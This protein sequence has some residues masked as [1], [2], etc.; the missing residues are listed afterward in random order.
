MRDADSALVP[1]V[2][3][4]NYQNKARHVSALHVADVCQASLLVQ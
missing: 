3:T 4:C 1:I 2:F